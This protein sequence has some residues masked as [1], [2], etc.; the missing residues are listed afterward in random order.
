MTRYFYTVEQIDRLLINKMEQ[1]ARTLAPD[2]ERCGHEYL[3]LNPARPDKTKGSF[4]INLATGVWKDFAARHG[5][6][7][8]PG[9]ALIAYLATEGDFTRAILWAKDWL[10]LTDK[11][12]DPAIAQRLEAQIKRSREDEARAKEGRLRAAFALYLES[13]PLDGSDPASRYLQARGI[14]GAELAAKRF[15]RS[16]KFHPEI[17]HRSFPGKFPALIACQSLEGLR[18]GFA[19][20]H[21]IYLKQDAGVWTKA[22]GKK[23][24]KVTL[25]YQ[26]GASI[27]I[28]QGASGKQLADAPKGEWV[29]VTE[30]V[31]DGLSLAV[32]LPEARVLAA[33][34]IA[35]IG[36]LS[37]P[38]H[39][40]GVVVVRDNDEPDSEA[41]AQ[42][43]KALLDLADKH[44]VK[45]A[46]MPEIYK[47]VNDCLLDKRRENA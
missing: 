32:A 16:L 9:L 22:F 31:E 27:R 37:L 21:R 44:A 45:V 18:S 10:G 23:D 13:R 5:S 1:L 6:K 42:L 17:S 33:Y 41:A 25:G 20:I 43:E 19:G 8:L 28:Q 4:S 40:G 26:T 30:G 34:S 36:R 29:H 3:A 11:A 7:A 12:P 47:D 39:I 2:G 15:P 14:D 35:A 24:S 46:R 38:E